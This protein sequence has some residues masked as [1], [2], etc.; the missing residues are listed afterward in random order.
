MKRLWAGF[1]SGDGT[2]EVVMGTS[3]GFFGAVLT[4]VAFMQREWFEAAWLLLVAVI[5]H[6]W[7]DT[8][9]HLRF[10]RRL[11]RD[12]AEADAHAGEHA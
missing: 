10:I 4:G 1:V 8:Y 11:R 9:R 5:A 3:I 2:Y 6:A 12:L 7:A